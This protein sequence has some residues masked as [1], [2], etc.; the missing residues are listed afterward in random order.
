M[1]RMFA[2]LF[3]SVMLLG[4]AARAEYRQIELTIFGMD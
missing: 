4:S 2:L 1:K 3:V